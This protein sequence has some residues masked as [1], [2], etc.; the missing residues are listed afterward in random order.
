M[1]EE[2]RPPKIRFI[3]VAEDEV[4]Q[5]RELGQAVFGLGWVYRLAAFAGVSTRTAQRWSAGESTVPAGVLR[6]LDEQRRRL[7]ETRYEQQLYDLLDAI[8]ATGLSPHVVSAHLRDAA[9]RVKPEE[10]TGS[11]D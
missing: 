9:A 2:T 5:F 11:K 7:N 1:T 4:A 3:K 6:D 8:L 10:S